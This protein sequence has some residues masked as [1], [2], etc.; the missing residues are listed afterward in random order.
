MGNNMLFPNV[1]FINCANDPGHDINLFNF[2]AQ[3]A[4]FLGK[5][6]LSSLVVLWQQ[7]NLSH[8]HLY[9]WFIFVDIKN[10]YTYIGL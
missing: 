3:H 4:G 6:C 7:Y 8:S 5:I 10:I 9:G 2:H 1:D